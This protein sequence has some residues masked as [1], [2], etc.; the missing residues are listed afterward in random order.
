VENVLTGF[1]IV[2]LILF[3]TLRLSSKAVANQ[4][5]IQAVWQQM[6]KRYDDQSRTQF[7]PVR[8]QISS[9]GATLEYAYRNIG[10]TRLTNFAHWDVI[11]EY[12]DTAAHHI[13]WLRYAPKDPLAGEWT[14]KAISSDSEGQQP[15]AV[16]RGI[17]NP[18]EM[19]ILQIKLAPPVA[20]GKSV[21]TLL[22][23]PNGVN[24]S[25][26]YRRSQP[27]TLTAN[28]GLN[29]AGATSAVIDS[30]L[31]MADDPD[32]PASQRVY[33]VTTGPAHG[34]LSLGNRFTQDEINIRRLTY[35]AEATPSPD[36]F[37]FTVSDGEN[38]E[39]PYTFEVTP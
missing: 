11:V 22:A 28:T 16:E 31:L 36:S 27:L 8:A 18:G 21:N 9:D 10:A 5:A 34:W 3:A 15:E 30:G 33:S 6:Q 35:T 25:F 4:Q 32:S 26:I 24:A 2:F 39:G 37:E 17:W 19:L 13:S 20:P 1:V 38:T 23:A 14:V 12:D 29:L 7:Q